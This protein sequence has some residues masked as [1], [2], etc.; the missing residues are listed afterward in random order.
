LIVFSLFDDGTY[1]VG[2]R[3]LSFLLCAMSLKNSKSDRLYSHRGFDFGKNRK[4]HKNL[5]AK[6]REIF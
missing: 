3:V 4:T 6:E 5:R 2:Q 1:A